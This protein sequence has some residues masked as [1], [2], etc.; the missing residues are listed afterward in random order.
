[1]IDILLSAFLV[2]IVLVGIHSYFGIEIIRRG[3]IFTDLAIG[4]MAALGAAISLL[5]FDGTYIYPLSLLMAILAALLVSY[6][7]IRS[8]HPEAII[9][10]LYAFSLSAVYIVLSKSYHG[11]EEFYKLLASD[12][13]FT[14]LPKI[15][16]TALLYS[17]IGIMLYFIHHS[18]SKRF[19]DILFFALFAL[20]V[21]SSVKLAG[22]LIV[23]ALLLSPAMIALSLVQ[24]HHLAF[25]WIAGIAFNLISILIS[26]TFDLPTGYTLVALHTLAA[27]VIGL[28]FGK[29]THTAKQI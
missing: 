23:F 25:A 24:K 26:Y 4:Q 22:V 2:S 12:I 28:V 10:L 11:M 6:A 18:A 17:V 29:N 9:G 21:T 13:L 27:I 3:I 8:H 7:T 1:M 19:K 20:T 16:E 14:S 5:L 15:I